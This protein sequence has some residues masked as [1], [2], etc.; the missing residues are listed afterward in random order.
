MLALEPNYLRRNQVAATVHPSLAKHFAVAYQISVVLVGVACLRYQVGIECPVPPSLVPA[1][2]SP[3]IVHQIPLVVHLKHQFPSPPI[4]GVPIGF[5]ILASLV[6]NSVEL[7]ELA[8]AHARRVIL[9]PG[10]LLER[11][12]VILR[13]RPLGA[14]VPLNLA[15]L[16]P[17]SCPIPAWSG[18]CLAAGRG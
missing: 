4:A 13:K 15:V 17:L 12:T 7:I 3:R 5:A 1:L 18:Q 9:F 16:L 14:L 6:H 10:P 8:L 2:P 11:R